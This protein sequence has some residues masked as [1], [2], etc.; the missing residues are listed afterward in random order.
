[1]TKVSQRGGADGLREMQHLRAVATV[2]SEKMNENFPRGTAYHEAAHAVLA[3]SLH[4]P[5][6]AVHVSA[7]DA[8]GGAEIGN[9]DKLS[10]CEHIALCSAGIVAEEI[11]GFANHERAGFNDRLKILELLKAVVIENGNGAELRT[12]GYNYARTQLITHKEK[13]VALAER[14][15]EIGRI[16][17]DEFLQLMGK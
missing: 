17:A 3:W 10:L 14:L 1:M 9:A 11:L 12:E 13:V 4:L 8:S 7:D 6:R 2:T 5:V 15:I 16:D